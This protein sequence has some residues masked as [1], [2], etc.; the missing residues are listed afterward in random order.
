MAYGGMAAVP[1]RVAAAEAALA[2]KPFGE[3]TFEAA[4]AAVEAGLTPITD[5]RASAAYRRL[6]AGNLLRR[7]WLEASGAPAPTQVLAAE[8]AR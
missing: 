8:E 5:M 7:F 3:P 2:G 6:V 4:A 1:L